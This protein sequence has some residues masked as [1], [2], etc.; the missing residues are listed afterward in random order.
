[1]NMIVDMCGK[2]AN[3]DFRAMDTLFYIC[4]S[5]LVV[6]VGIK[7]LNYLFRGESSSI[8]RHEDVAGVLLLTK[9]VFKAI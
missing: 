5:Y 4:G 3:F 7:T 6:D 2:I 8:K 1:M 9:A